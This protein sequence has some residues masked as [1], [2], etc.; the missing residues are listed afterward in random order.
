MIDNNHV[1]NGIGFL[2]FIGNK[3]V[4]IKIGDIRDYNF[5]ESVTVNIDKVVHLA[6]IVG[7]PACDKDEK[8]ANDVNISGTLNVI[9]ACK[10]NKLLSMP[11]LKNLKNKKIIKICKSN[12][13]KA[14]FFGLINCIFYFCLVFTTYFIY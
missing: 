5:I 12:L 11:W 8:L 2:E 14:F 4:T 7:E 10:K 3:N 13:F 9:K 6:A 1:G